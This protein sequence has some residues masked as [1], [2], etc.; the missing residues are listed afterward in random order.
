MKSK[1]EGK[2]CSENSGR[3]INYVKIL[4]KYIILAAKN[5]AAKEANSKKEGPKMLATI[6]YIYIYIRS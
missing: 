1:Q 4:A 2:N 3:D 5:K 6:R